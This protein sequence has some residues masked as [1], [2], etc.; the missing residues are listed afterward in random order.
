M[1]FSVFPN[2]Y[3]NE[4]NMKLQV[5]SEDLRI[6]A[7]TKRM[8]SF[9]FILLQDALQSLIKMIKVNCNRT[10][11]L[12]AFFQVNSHSTTKPPRN[13]YIKQLGNTSKFSKEVKTVILTDSRQKV[14]SYL[15][16]L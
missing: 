8:W 1:W 3:A 6:R 9:I 2:N 16:V 13:K 14:L 7:L 15:S 10:Q 4:Y 5:I 12:H 11:V